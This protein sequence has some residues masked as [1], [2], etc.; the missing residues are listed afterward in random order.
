[1]TICDKLLIENFNFKKSLFFFL[2]L[3]NVLREGTRNGV[4]GQ[5]RGKTFYIG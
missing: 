1:M 3:L 5:H 4:G 2:E